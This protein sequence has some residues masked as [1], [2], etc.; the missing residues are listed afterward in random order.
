[1]VGNYYTLLMHTKETQRYDSIHH[2]MVTVCVDQLSL[3]L[4]DF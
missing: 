4:R 1:M 2:K 3:T